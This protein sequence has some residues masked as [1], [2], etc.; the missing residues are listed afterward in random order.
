MSDKLAATH[1][2]KVAQ[3]LGFFWFV[4]SWILSSE[5]RLLMLTQTL[6]FHADSRNY[7]KSITESSETNSKIGVVLTDRDC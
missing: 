5:A 6:I 2:I 3:S 7:L 4:T 1:I